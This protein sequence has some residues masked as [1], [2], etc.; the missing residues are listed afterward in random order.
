MRKIVRNNCVVL[1]Q[2]L[3]IYFVSEMFISYETLHKY[4]ILFD[5][6]FGS[7]VLFNTLEYPLH[8]FHGNRKLLIAQFLSE[9]NHFSFLK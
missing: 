9:G 6:S 8:W 3:L 5:V 7:L 2:S 4:L 1:Q